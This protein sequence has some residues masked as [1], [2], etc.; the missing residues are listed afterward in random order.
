MKKIN[1]SKL[2]AADQPRKKEKA[3]RPPGT[4]GR[5]VGVAVFWFLFAFMLLV[6]FTTI[7]TRDESAGPEIIEAPENLATSEA[8]TSFAQEFA[9]TYF[10]WE[11][12]AKGFEDRQDRLAPMLADG[13]DKNAGLIT[14][15][16]AWRSEAGEIRVVM[17]EE[18]GADKALITLEVEQVLSKTEDEKDLAETETHY[19]TVPV[20]YAEAFGVYE[21]PNFT[22]I[23]KEN[24]V[25]RFALDGAVVPG[26]IETNIKNFLPTF[27]Q[28]YTTDTPDKL[29]YF[30]QDDG[31]VKGLEGS[32]VFERVQDA[33]MVQA[34]NGDIIVQA[35]VELKSPK[36]GTLYGMNYI[37][38]VK[39]DNGRYIVTNMNEGVH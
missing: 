1:F 12:S 32:M 9:A 14:T 31:K 13:L 3:Y 22:A 15:N 8:A 10:T 7:G 6:V 35:A 30:L 16:L 38:T 28:S 34:A 19:F 36:T 20:A 37:L 24:A 18:Q 33:R 4:M 21:L 11:P 26:E 5:K 17:V 27:F 29:S 2:K 39:E 25:Q 23:N